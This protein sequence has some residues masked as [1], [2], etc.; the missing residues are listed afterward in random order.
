MARDFS[1]DGRRL[2]SDSH[3]TTA[4]ICDLTGIAN[5]KGATILSS[6]Q[7][8]SLWDALADA[9]A[10]KAYRAGWRLTSDPDATFSFLRKHLR[11]AQVDTASIAK[12]L[13][14]LDGNDFEDRE[15]ASRRLAE[16]GDLACPAVRKAL[17]GG[18][19]PE[20]RRLE[21]LARKLDGPVEA[22]ELAHALRGVEV[23]EHIGSAEA[24][25]LLEELGKGAEGSRVTRDAKDSLQR[26]ARS[27]PDR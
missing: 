1:P 27:S 14:A 6:D 4:L 9:D 19:S 18:P 2:I 13:A 26:L 25:Q 16:F 3:D 24:R 11:P 20:A 5:E 22:P 23:L 7:L 12:A 17:E 15:A 21:E 10:G 8:A